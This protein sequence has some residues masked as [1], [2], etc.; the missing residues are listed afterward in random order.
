MV[1]S[2]PTV[3]KEAVA[4]SHFPT[5]HQAFIFRA[6]EYVPMEKIAKVLKTDIDNVRQAAEDMGLPDYDPKNVWMKR[7]YVTI[8][9]RMWHILPYEQLLELLEMDEEELAIIMRDEDFLNIKLENK[10]RCERVEWRELSEEEKI[11]TREIK[12]VMQSLDFSGKHPFEFEYNVPTIEFA[13]EERFSTRMIYAFS[14]LYQHAFDVDSE[15][16]LPDEQLKAYQDLGINGIWTQ[17]VL[18]Q[19]TSFPFAPEVSKGYEKRL[20]KMRAM[21]KR[22]DKYGIKLYLYLNEPRSMPIEFFKNHPELK[23]HVS[24]E[25]ACLCI[26]TQ[27]VQDYLKDAVESI[28][29]AVPLIGGFFT[30]TRSENLTNCYSHSGGEFNPC[31]CPRCKERNIGEVISETVGC[32]LEGARRVNDDIK[33]MAWSWRWDEYNGEIIRKLPKGVILMSQSEL[34]IPF[35]IGGINGSVLDYSM[36]IIGPG[37]RACAEWDLAKECGLEI[38]AKVQI[39]TTWEASTVPAI[40][41]ASSIDDHISKLKRQGVRHLLLSWTLGGY[42]CRNIAVAAKH[43]YEK[44]S[45]ASIDNSISEAEKQ[46]V[47]AFSEFPFH[48]YVLYCGP[49]NA[50]PSN[51]L[52]ERATSYKATMTCFAYDD[53]E[54]WRS[55]YPIDVFESQFEKLCQKWEIGLNMIGENDDSEGAVMAKAAY[56]LFKS[57][58]NQIRFIRARDEGRFADAVLEAENELAIARQMLTLMNKNAAIGYEAANHYYFSKGQI[59]EKMINCNYI[60][61]YFSK[62]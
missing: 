62:A 14:G 58:L 59:A 20:E 15:E 54:S 30:I 42:P 49:Q 61:D 31:N 50:G 34:D 33:V 57:S 53:L 13:G 40:P 28:C 9:R 55:I 52:F 10:P 12:K 56:C 7:G 41:V 17:G 60:I 18:S 38:G 43:F 19:L 44:C 3:E 23:G 2:L 25:D 37:E 16:F 27:P 22:L 47:K 48:V 29:R 1:Y 46:F 45:I 24:G 32:I 39:N 6:C 21:T 11:R 8:I 26:S 35:E 4:L 5:K 36:S 51:M